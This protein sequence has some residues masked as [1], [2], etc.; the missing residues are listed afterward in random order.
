MLQY[1]PRTTKMQVVEDTLYDIDRIIKL[2]KDHL[3]HAR[4]KMSTLLIRKDLRSILKLEIL[5]G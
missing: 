3:N 2:L 1:V 4:N 5:F